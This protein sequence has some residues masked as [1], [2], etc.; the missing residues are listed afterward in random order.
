MDAK[1][2]LQLAT[3]QKVR[4]LFKSFLTV[5][6]DLKEEHNR[7]FGTLYDSLPENYRPQIVQAN[8]LDNGAYSYM[9]KKVLDAGNDAIRE[10]DNE[11]KK[12]EVDFKR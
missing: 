5:I 11:L 2:Y 7:N 1:D 8:Y 6:E 12:Y 10:I 4:F 3:E 9:R